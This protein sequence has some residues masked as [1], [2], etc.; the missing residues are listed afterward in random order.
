MTDGYS[1]YKGLDKNNIVNV[2]CWA[3]L[4]RRFMDAKKAMPK[5]KSA[6]NSAVMTALGYCTKIFKEDKRINALALEKRYQERQDY[7]KPILDDFYAWAKT[8]NAA[9]KGA[10]GKALTYLE[11]QW[12]YLNNVLLDGRLELT[13]NLAERS[14]KPFVID[15]K[16]FLFAVSPKGAQGSAIMFSIVETAKENKL[17]PYNYLCYIFRTT[18]K[19][20]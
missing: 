1:A 8:V 13:N 6:A 9:P 12:P 15:R 5:G 10:L 19:L 2:C 3:H 14:I 16:N 18:P 7:L 20:D 4:R 17:N 11:N